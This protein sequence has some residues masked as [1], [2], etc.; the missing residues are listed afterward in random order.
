M[1][2]T[3]KGE[4]I[5]TALTKEYGAEKGKQVLYAGKNSGK[6]T[7]I[8]MTEMEKEE[9][10]HSGAL[11]GHIA[12]LGQ[13]SGLLNGLAE[14]SAKLRKRVDSYGSRRGDKKKK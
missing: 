8:D 3:S 13:V 9:A 2:L 6:F 4:E 7:G 10:K 5:L 14:D 11:E 12:K 1:P